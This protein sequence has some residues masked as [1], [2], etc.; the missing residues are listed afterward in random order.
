MDSDN[1]HDMYSDI[2]DNI[3]DIVKEEE[4]TVDP[5]RIEYYGDTQYD[6]IMGP[7]PWGG[8]KAASD[9]FFMSTEIMLY[10]IILKYLYLKF[11]II[12]S[13]FTR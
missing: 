9:G 6:I 4:I 11:L 12:I 8:N 5:N 3:T 13:Y 1:I 10:G 7:N 2:I